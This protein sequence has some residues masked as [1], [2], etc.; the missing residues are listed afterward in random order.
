MKNLVIGLALTVILVLP[1]TAVST[2]PIAEKTSIPR[3]LEIMLRIAKNGY[4]VLSNIVEK[5]NITDPYIHEL[6]TNISKE[7]NIVEDLISRGEYEEAHRYLVGIL[8]EL[9]YLSI[10]I[11]HELPLEVKLKLRLLHTIKCLNRTIGILRI[12]VKHYVYPKN[13]SLAEN[14]LQKLDNLSS[15]LASIYNELNTTKNISK[16]EF[17][18]LYVRVAYVRAELIKIKK[19]IMRYFVFERVKERLAD[20]I[21]RALSLVDKR[22]R[23]LSILRDRELKRGCRLRAMKIS[24]GIS[25][26]REHKLKLYELLGEIA[27]AKDFKELR[28]CGMEALKILN[29]IQRIY[30]YTKHIAK[31]GPC[32]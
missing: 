2:V 1:L 10:L 24:I 7:L 3:N 5:Y 18:T 9:H 30:V 15:E 12:A 20:R 14:I 13:K 25:K 8:S 6:L 19:M 23:E 26:I 29:E 4:R 32:R 22:I 11:G 21:R 28:S 27:K 31:F 16:D 17:K